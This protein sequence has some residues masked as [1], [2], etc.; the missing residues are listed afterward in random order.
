MTRQTGL[1]RLKVASLV[2]ATNELL[3]HADVAAEKII[4]D[5]LVD[6][7]ATALD[8][9]FIDPSN[10]GSA[11]V[12]PAAVTSEADASQ[13]SPSESVFDFSDS[14]TG[15]PEV[16]VILMHPFQAARLYGSA[17]PDIGARGGTWGGFPVI[18]SSSVPEGIF[19]LMDPTRIA[20]AMGDAMVRT[21]QNADIE[22]EDGPANASITPA[23]ATLTSLFQVSATAILG[24]V[25]CN[26]RNTR[27][28][29]VLVF[30]AQ[31]F[32][33]AGGL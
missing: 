11:N 2:V 13:D 10:T 17:R 3:Q 31:S 28:G 19:V 22:M 23:Q 27:P 12:R 30:S 4:R 16:S 7:L 20:V 14:F 5:E 26:W 24:E 29:S 32:G 33:L 25:S 18:T 21:S 8:V 1:A 6:A 15:R 9:A